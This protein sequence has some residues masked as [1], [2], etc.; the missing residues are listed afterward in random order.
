[1]IAWLDNVLLDEA[2]VPKW[3][4]IISEACS[5]LI[6]IGFDPEMFT[7]KKIHEHGYTDE[8]LFKLIKPLHLFTDLDELA[9]LTA[10]IPKNDFVEFVDCMKWL[11][12]TNEGLHA[13]FDSL[14]R[15]SKKNLWLSEQHV[16]LAQKLV[17]STAHDR[18]NRKT[19]LDEI[20]KSERR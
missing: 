5:L 10:S 14:T 7:L 11:T 20:N 2:F 13:I 3:Q 15:L 17:S 12:R 16:A 6:Q 19:I 8:D 18:L 1:L 9:Y 4:V